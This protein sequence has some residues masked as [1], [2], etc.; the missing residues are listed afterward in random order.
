VINEILYM[1]KNNRD[2]NFKWLL[3]KYSV[4]LRKVYVLWTKSSKRCWK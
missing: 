3:K 2:G 1:I 4:K